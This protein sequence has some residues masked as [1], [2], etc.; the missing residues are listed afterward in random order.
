MKIKDNHRIKNGNV[1]CL[2][3]FCDWHYKSIEEF[4]EHKNEEFDEGFNPQTKE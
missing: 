3:H 4:E 2:N 1:C